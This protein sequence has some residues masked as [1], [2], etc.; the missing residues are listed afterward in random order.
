MRVLLPVAAALA[1]IL[2]TAAAVAAEDPPG[3]VI[4]RVPVREKVVALTFDDGPRPPFTGE[5]LDVLRDQGVV[6][7]F[8]LIGENVA[9]HPGLARRIKAEGHALGNHGWAHRRL[10]GLSR[11]QAQ[12]EI[13]RGARA[14]RS[15]TGTHPRILRPPYGA[16]DGRLVGDRGIAAQLGQQLVMWSVETRDWATRSPLRVAAGTVRGI[17]P[18]AVVLLHDGGGNRDHVVTATRWMVGHLARKGYR[19]VTVPELLAMSSR[20]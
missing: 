7:T 6:A 10:D 3:S 12:N 20:R 13:L 17:E 9:R 18:G 11:V 1:G 19:F 5:I 4:Y 16:I 2:A 14:I 8:F 15:A